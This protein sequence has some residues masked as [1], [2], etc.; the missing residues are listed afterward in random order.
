VLRI[1]SD[2]LFVLAALAMAVQSGMEGMSNDWMTRYY[3]I[4]TLAEPNSGESHAQLALVAL[5]SGM[6]LSRLALSGL[7]KRVSSRLVLLGSIAVAAAGA[8]LLKQAN[9]YGLSLAGTFFIGVGLAA[10]FPIVLGYVGD[11]YP[12]QSG[13]AFSM[14]F[15]IALLG[16]MAINKSFGYI[17]EHYGVQRYPTMLLALLGGS[18]MLL[19]LVVRQPGRITPGRL[20]N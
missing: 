16:N 6:A 7:L 18:A 1:L 9:S 14:I 4:V 17:A 12:Q 19:A 8:I 13:T 2:P 15:V 3:K 20:E 11:R 10:G 5:T